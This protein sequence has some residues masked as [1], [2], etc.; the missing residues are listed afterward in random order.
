MLGL[1]KA[2]PPLFFPI[3]VGRNP[4]GALDVGTDGM[5]ATQM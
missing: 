5:V 2:V 4:E 3:I 1:D